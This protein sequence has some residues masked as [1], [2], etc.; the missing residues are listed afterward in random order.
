[1]ASILTAF[2]AFWMSLDTSKDRI[3]ISVISL[4]AVYTQLTYAQGSL[5]ATSYSTDVRAAG[6]DRIKVIFVKK[7][8][9]K[10][11]EVHKP[12]SFTVTGVPRY[13]TEYYRYAR[14]FVCDIYLLACMLNVLFIVMGCSILQ[15]IY[16]EEQLKNKAE[17]LG[18]PPKLQKGRNVKARRNG[19][20]RPSANGE[21]NWQPGGDELP[22]ESW[23]PQSHTVAGQLEKLLKK[24]RFHFHHPAR[25]TRADRLDSLA[26]GD[27]YSAHNS[28]LE[29]RQCTRPTGNRRRGFDHRPYFYQCFWTYLY[30]VVNILSAV[31]PLRQRK[32]TKLIY[33][34][35]ASRKPDLV[36]AKA[37]LRASIAAC[38]SLLS[39]SLALPADQASQLLDQQSQT[40][41]R[42]REFVWPRPELHSRV[43]LVSHR[44]WTN[45]VLV[46]FLG[47]RRVH[48]QG[49]YQ[50]PQLSKTCVNGQRRKI[51]PRCRIVWYRRLEMSCLNACFLA[52]LAHVVTS[53]NSLMQYSAVCPAL[54]S[55][56]LQFG[57]EIVRLPRK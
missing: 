25:K 49:R 3:S 26:G 5:P 35:E 19:T 29:P 34:F 24:S 57:Y 48:R 43:P 14:T 33:V 12:F 6:H 21:S 54:V 28:N 38:N 31:G 40:D 15:K 45:V 44:G 9:G 37:N 8:L 10:V 16:K 55:A 47:L 27:I 13:R 18:K 22:A 20:S 7:S 50:G 23:M 46:L 2:A 32:M 17:V 30:I 11:K 4:L 56:T 53:R 42:V 52:E 39:A 41:L 1:M 36:Q 51:G